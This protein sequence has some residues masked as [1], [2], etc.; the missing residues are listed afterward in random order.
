MD[1]TALITAKE[2]IIK[3]YRGAVVWAMRALEY[4]R[5][6]DK[7]EDFGADG[8]QEYVDILKQ[9]SRRELKEVAV[10]IKLMREN[11]DRIDNKLMD[12][13]R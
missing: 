7:E 6:F 2:N 1:K 3:E 13:S 4:K 5:R 9:D 8:L 11:I 12:G 10:N